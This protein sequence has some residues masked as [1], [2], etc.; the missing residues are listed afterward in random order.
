MLPK[1]CILMGTYNGEK[2]LK[3]QLDSFETQTHQNWVLY[4]SDDGSQDN[5]LTMLNA[6]RDKIGE[7]RVFIFEGPRKGFCA[8][9]LS[10]IC[11]DDIDGDYY[12]FSDQDDVWEANKLQRAL[13]CISGIVGPA[14]YGARTLLV[15]EHN[16]PIGYSSLWKRKP[17]FQNALVQSIASGN[18][19]LLNQAARELL[20]KY[21]KDIDVVSH[22]W[23]AYQVVSGCGG[24]VYYDAVPT[25][26][27][28]QHGENLIGEN[29]SLWAKTQRVKFFFR[30]RFQH[31][32]QKN[33]EALLTVTD[34]LSS[35]KTSLFYFKKLKESTFFRKL[36]FLKKSHVYR[37]TFLGT[38]GLFFGCLV[39][40]V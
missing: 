18:T 20:K 9:F 22:D 11:R 14:L 31:W 21:S 8:N 36:I 27:Y 33:I 15:N 38:L 2:F 34:L 5:T 4:V 24:V 1:I 7:D 37:Q 17:S 10:L 13:A 26:R 25:V 16:A 12:A 32:M 40:K 35:N 3:A 6:F 29:K 23:W 19:M 30:G 28:R 39:G